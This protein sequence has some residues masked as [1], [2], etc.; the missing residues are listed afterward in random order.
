MILGAEQVDLSCPAVI[1]HTFN[2]SEIEWSFKMFG[3]SLWVETSQ[4]QVL[5]K[6][7]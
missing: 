7:Y 4:L 5:S 1:F 2:H 3:L 6:Y